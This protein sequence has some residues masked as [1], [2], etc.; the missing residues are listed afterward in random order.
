M[1]RKV[2]PVCLT[3]C[4]SRAECLFVARRR[5]GIPVWKCKQIRADERL[6]A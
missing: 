2:C 4:R 6:T 3:F 5:L 1:S